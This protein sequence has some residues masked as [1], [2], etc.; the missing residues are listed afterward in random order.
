MDKKELVILTDESDLVN[1]LKLIKKNSLVVCSNFELTEKLKVNGIKFKTLEDF[2]TRKEL[3]NIGMEAIL[4]LR[5]WG[6]IKVNKKTLKEILTYKGIHFWDMIELSFADWI[7]SR[8]EKL[9]YIK[10]VKKIS[11]K[12]NIEKIIANE[13]NDFGK[14]AYLVAKAKKIH[15]ISIARGLSQKIRWYYKRYLW[16]YF[17]RCGIKLKELQQV[18]LSKMKI[19]FKTKQEKKN[20]ILLIVFIE[21]MIPVIYP[22]IKELEKNKDNQ[23]IVLRLTS[24]TERMKKSLDKK[25]IKSEPVE[26]Y[27]TETAKKRAK[28]IIKILMKG[29]KYLKL[30]KKFRKSITYLGIPVWD[31]VKYD[32]EYYFETRKRIEEI[33][34]YIE[35]LREAIKIEKPKILITLD[36]YSELGKPTM[37]LGK[38]NKVPTLCI[39][40]GLF[41]KGVFVFGPSYSDKIA[42]WGPKVKKI[43]GKR[44]F[45]PKKM[46]L[47]GSPGF[48]DLADKNSLQKSKEEIYKILNLNPSKKFFIYATQ[49][50]G[51]DKKLKRITAEMVFNAMKQFTNKYLVVKIHPREYDLSFYQNI[52]KKTGIHNIIIVKDVNLHK[53]I[54]NCELL[55][56]PFSTVGIEALIL[57]KPLITVNL[58]RRIDPGSF[59]ESGTINVKSTNELVSAIRY[60]LN[61]KNRE[62]ISKKV[63]RYIYN[64]T[65]ITNG[66]A[67]ERIIKLIYEMIGYGNAKF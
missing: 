21:T 46:V 49:P 43:L 65:Y 44:W 23:L 50:L 6:K 48:D 64:Y 16:H 41:G 9:Q 13:L 53:L 4:T 34:K 54:A 32:F 55:I 7:S 25:G 59:E 45:N 61:P 38:I 2:L 1:A 10:L 63:R 57:N 56:T 29:W 30:N 22:I 11:E 17:V 51:K 31:L 39:Q 36:D 26:R 27:M 62:K 28:N 19:N 18:V 52:A 5:K 60:I 67:T 40:H 58:T 66:K 12:K 15:F 37:L 20:K 3:E 33:V 35:C 8:I 42:I 14:A 24:P 47:T